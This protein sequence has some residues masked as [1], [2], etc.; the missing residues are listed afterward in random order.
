[1][2]RRDFIKVI[3][4][5]TVAWPVAARAQQTEP[6]KRI[7]VLAGASVSDPVYQRR[8]QRRVR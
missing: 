3:A 7:R 4:G 8:P 2:R 6:M 5:S 1:M